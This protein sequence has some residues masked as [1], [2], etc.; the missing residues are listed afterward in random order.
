M[1]YYEEHGGDGQFGRFNKNFEGPAGPRRPRTCNALLSEMPE[2]TNTHRTRHGL[3]LV[4][5]TMDA[6]TATAL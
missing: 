6:H 1:A 4:D 3:W 2:S 5:G